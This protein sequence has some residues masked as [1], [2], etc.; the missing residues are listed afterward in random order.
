MSRQGHRSLGLFL[1]LLQLALL[2]RIVLGFLLFLFLFLVSVVTHIG[3]FRFEV[4]NYHIPRQ[5]KKQPP[6]CSV[7]VTKAVGEIEELI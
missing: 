3:S 4:H 1:L 2:L 6:R 7:S 5:V